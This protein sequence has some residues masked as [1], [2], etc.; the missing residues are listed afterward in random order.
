M[1]LEG[2]TS[3]PNGATSVT[4]NFAPAF[5]AKPYVRHNVANDS[6]DVSKTVLGT[7]L[8]SWLQDGSGNYTGAVITLSG[9]TPSSNYK[10]MWE[11][12][13]ANGAVPTPAALTGVT[14]AGMRAGLNLSGMPDFRIPVLPMN[15]QG[16]E[17]RALDRAGLFGSVPSVEPVPVGPLQALPTD[18]ALP[19]SVDR[20][21]L[22]VG[23]NGRWARVPLEFSDNWQQQPWLVPFREGEVTIEP[24]AE[25]QAYEIEYPTPFGGTVMPR[26]LLQVTNTNTPVEL[27]SYNITARSTTGFTITFSDVPQ[28]P[29]EVYY[30]ARQIVLNQGGGGPGFENCLIL[31]VSN[32]VDDLVVGDSLGS[33]RVPYAGTITRIVANVKGAPTGAAIEL[34]VRRN[35][36]DI[37]SVP[38]TIDAGE[39]SSEDAA[40][41]FEFVVGGADLSEGD[42]IEVDVVQHGSIEPGIACKVTFYIVA[43]PAP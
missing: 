23:T 41:P 11:A 30:L 25:Q 4:I 24:V 40:V 3:I 32:E 33:C 16:R 17:M 28:G 20:N 6:A 9:A 26:V 21:W 8:T 37:L 22:Y 12:G 35:G 19:L 39:F 10:L 27:L 18:K 7:L 38:I 31:P 14:L 15:P 29:V 2:Q 43:V 34:M 13:I 5:A 42:L 1:Y 36:T